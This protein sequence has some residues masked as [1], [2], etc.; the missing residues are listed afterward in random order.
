MIYHVILCIWIWRGD[1]FRTRTYIR[2]S[3]RLSVCPSVCLSV[4][5]SVTPWTSQQTDGRTLSDSPTSWHADELGS[6]VHKLWFNERHG[7]SNHR[8]LDCLYNRLFRRRSKKTSKLHVTGLC[9]GKST[10]TG[11]FPAQSASNTESVSI[12]YWPFQSSLDCYMFFEQGNAGSLR[13]LSASCFS[14]FPGGKH[15]KHWRV[16]RFSFTL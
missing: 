10:M 13:S 7:V 16:C 14:V 3:V 11:E 9:E 2:H 8:R 5:L 15:R 6:C 4:C 1:W 12:S